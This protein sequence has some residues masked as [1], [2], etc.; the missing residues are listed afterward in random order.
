MKKLA[1]F[2]E[3]GENVTFN[4]TTIKNGLLIES[5]TVTPSSTIYVKGVDGAGNSY[6]RHIWVD[7]AYEMQI[8]FCARTHKLLGVYAPNV[9]N[10]MYELNRMIKANYPVGSFGMGSGIDSIILQSIEDGI[11]YMSLNVINHD[12]TYSQA[13]AV[14][15]IEGLKE[16]VYE[17]HRKYRKPYVFFE[18]KEDFDAAVSKLFK[19]QPNSRELFVNEMDLTKA[20]HRRMLPKGA[21]E[22]TDYVSGNMNY[23]CDPKH[24]VWIS[25]TA[26]WQYNGSKGCN[27]GW[28]FYS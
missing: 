20:K 11:D 1:S 16:M 23:G 19:E 12:L 24:G 6:D 5:Y 7:K 25:T 8:L 15:T 13:K 2:R 9:F 17:D 10:S 28:V 26:K 27:A 4:S 3:G 18:N 14:L 22:L 21:K